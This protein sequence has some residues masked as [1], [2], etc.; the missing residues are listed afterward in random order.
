MIV[1]DHGC[2]LCKCTGGSDLQMTRRYKILIHWM[3]I[4]KQIIAQDSLEALEN[5]YK[6]ENLVSRS[7]GH[8]SELQ[9]PC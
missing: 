3:P 2:M 1:F 8:T 7:E 6:N 5:L 9:S 4:V